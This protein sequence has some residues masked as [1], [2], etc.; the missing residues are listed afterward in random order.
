MGETVPI[1]II[2]IAF[3]TLWLSVYTF[4]MY[5]FGR[6]LAAR[7]RL[8]VPLFLAGGGIAIGSVVLAL[9]VVFLAWTPFVKLMVGFGIWL[10]HAQSSF[11]GYWSGVETG[12]KEDERRWKE[13]AD[14]WINSFE[15]SQM[16]AWM[17]DEE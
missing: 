15:E 9:P 4:G 5:Q 8:K 6:K 7:F 16:P 1:A 11:L 13:T 12:R 2:G 10:L 14:N 3:S 17:R